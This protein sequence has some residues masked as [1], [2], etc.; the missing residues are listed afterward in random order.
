MH[1]NIVVVWICNNTPVPTLVASIHTELN[2]VLGTHIEL[3]VGRINYESEL[4]WAQYFTSIV[5][6]YPLFA[7]FAY[8]NY[9]ANFNEGKQ[10]IR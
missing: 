7:R 1:G 8:S 9:V 2:T 10:N 3:C 5:V 4:R 6:N